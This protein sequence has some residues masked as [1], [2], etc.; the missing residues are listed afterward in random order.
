[1]RSDTGTVL[2]TVVAGGG[3]RATG[4]LPPGRYAYSVLRASG[5]TIGSGRFDVAATTE[6]MLP[7][8]E[9]PVAASGGG[10]SAAPARAGTPLRTT[11]WPYLLVLLLLCAEWVAR[12]RAGLR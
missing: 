9:V 1:V 8:P 10:A 4:E 5:D 6:E 11:P 7:T 2:D 3:T 12:R